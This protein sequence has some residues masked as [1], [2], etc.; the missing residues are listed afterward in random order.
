M[1]KPRRIAIALDLQWPYKRHSALFV[2][3]QQYARQ[4]GWNSVIDDFAAET[5]AVAATA[6]S[7]LLH[8]AR[9]DGIIARASKQLAT[10]AARWDI[11][12]V[13][14]WLNSPVCDELPGVFPDYAA[15]GRAAAEHLLARGLRRFAF[16]ARRDRG[17]L[18]V[19]QAFG[20]TAKAGGFPCVQKVVPHDTRTYA[21]WQQASQQIDTWMNHWQLP[22][23]LAVNDEDTARGI[24]LMCERRGWRV[25]QDVAIVAGL[26]EEVLCENPRPSLTSIE[27]GYERLGWEAA[28]LLEKLMHASHTKRK[29]KPAARPEHILLPPKGL[30]VR[31]STD[32]YAVED[33][34]IAAALLFIS[35]NSRQPISPDDVA[36]A[37][38]LEPR[39]L[40][41]RFAK[42]LG[43]T[44]AG[45]ILRA[46]LEQAKRDLVHS[47]RSLAAIARD[48]GFGTARQMCEVF[49]REMGV[50][51]RDYRQQRQAEAGA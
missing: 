8:S 50:T 37:V 39:T 11:P 2:G 3:T 10:Q 38:Q 20:D 7:K 17:C 12:L 9:Y 43:R 42:V 44:I 34:T 28:Q 6:E 1:P 14:V 4:H 25:P 18:I 49:Q 27:V 32:F 31:E 40:R 21:A 24:M 19:A 51:P 16:V 41:R 15:I 35:Q 23:G 36:Q 48:V 26:N 47:D 30:I 5:L 29:A 45:E 33:E 13:N 46:R 22:M